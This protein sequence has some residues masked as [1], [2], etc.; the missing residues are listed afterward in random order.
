[1]RWSP[2]LPACVLH[3]MFLPGGCA[4]TSVAGE[5]Q[6]DKALINRSSMR[7]PST[8]IPVCFAN[9]SWTLKDRPPEQGEPLP[10][11]IVVAA[12]RHEF[13]GKTN[14][15]LTG[16]EPCSDYGPGIEIAWVNELRPSGGY[17]PSIDGRP[18]LVHLAYDFSKQSRKDWLTEY[19]PRDRH[20]TNACIELSALHEFM[21]VVALSL[22]ENEHPDSN[23]YITPTIEEKYIVEA[24][25]YKD[26][27]RSPTTSD[28]SE[29]IASDDLDRDV[30]RIRGEDFDERSVMNPCFY[31]NVVKNKALYGERDHVFALSEG[32]V[33]HV[34][35]MYPS[36]GS[37]QDGDPS[38]CGNKRCE[39]G[40]TS[41]TCPDDCQWPQRPPT[42]RGNW[43]IHEPN[44]RGSIDDAL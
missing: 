28:G 22:H 21:H 20:T 44:N 10:E 13:N 41:Q 38:S 30:I 5:R 11:D 26:V 14:I 25:A 33:R 3:V 16:F 27:V 40:E 37:A 17:G 42:T 9:P 36:A 34:N 32:D 12:L 43:P 19:C 29:S 2:L 15:E 8:S 39:P 4:A 1:M 18:T 23:C 7:W 6:A 31:R 35:W 24:D